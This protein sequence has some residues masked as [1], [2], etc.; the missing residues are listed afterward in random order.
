MSILGNIKE[1]L[2]DNLKATLITSAIVTG[3]GLSAWDVWEGESVSHSGQIIGSR[4]DTDTDCDK[5]GKC[6]TETDYYLTIK[7]EGQ[8]EECEVGI[9]NYFRRSHGELIQFKYRRGGVSGH[10][11]FC[12]V[13]DPEKDF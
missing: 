1:N 9:I 8:V 3:L 6:T 2:T 7:H 12:T 4:I 11:W 5:D 10:H 13:G